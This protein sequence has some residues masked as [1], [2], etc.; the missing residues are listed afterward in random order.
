MMGRPFT[1]AM[2]YL[3]AIVFIALGLGT[4]GCGD[5][6]TVSEGPPVRLSSLAVTPP[7]A[8]QPD[9]SSNVT[10]YRATV[11]TTDSSVIVRAT[12]ESSTATMTI[13]GQPAGTD[14]GISVTLDLAP[15]T[16]SIFIRITDQSGAQ[17]T[18]VVIVTRPASSNTD[19]RSLS[20][21][22]GP[23]NPAFR[24]GT[25][26]YTAQVGS[27][28]ARV[29]VTATLQD[30]TAALDVDGQGTISGQ[31]RAID[32]G[33]PGSSK[34][35]TIVV[36]AP[37]GSLKSYLVT[38]VRAALGGNFNLGKLTVSPGT[39]DPSFKAS[40]PRYTVNVGSGTDRVVVTATRQESSSTLQVNGQVANSGQARTIDLQDPGLPTDIE[41]LVIAQNGSRQPYVITMNRAALSADNNL[42]TLSVSPGTL[43]PTFTPDQL[44]YTVDVATGVS[45]LTVTATVQDSNASLMINGQGISSGQ[46]REI[47][48]L[49]PPGSNTLIAILVRAPSG[50]EKTYTVTVKRPLPSSDAALSA[51]T[52]SAGTLNPGF[53]AGT[54]NYTVNVPASVDSLTVTATKSDPNA[55]AS[56][57][58][59]VIAAPGVATGSVSGPLG[60]GTT[61]LFTIT[62][63][64]QDGVTTRP[65]TINVFRDSR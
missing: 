42:K 58:G 15:S 39:L 45:S 57:S 65:Y 44:P 56:A 11:S 64:A 12:P 37:N 41:I 25:T 62:V 52:V 60:L 20:L 33:D 53:A 17:T 10:D 34:D 3:A 6:A 16:K 26:K 9:F 38:V 36:T 50:A 4:Y 19:L 59:S 47:S 24:A 18:Y 61:T 30:P 40:T 2:Q 14:Q 55:V 32:L 43:T 21:S 8:L 49:A 63:T 31:A 23:L 48:P 5:S 28:T 1:I 54:I 29:S 35:I 13:D 51:L 46:P 27:G 22:P 7:G